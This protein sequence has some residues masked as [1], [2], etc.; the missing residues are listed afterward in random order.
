M[1]AYGRLSGVNAFD[2]PAVEGKIIPSNGTAGLLEYRHGVLPDISQR[3]GCKDV[4]INVARHPWAVTN[5]IRLCIFKVSKQYIP[6]LNWQ[7]LELGD[8]AVKDT[9]HQFESFGRDVL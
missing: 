6:T 1:T 4:S 7:R 8:P 5:Q 9:D 3:P 2:Q